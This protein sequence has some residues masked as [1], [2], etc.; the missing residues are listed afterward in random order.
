MSKPSPLADKAHTAD[1]IERSETTLLGAA[2]EHYVMAEL[3]RR[4]YIA[5]LA[6]QGVPNMDIVVTDISG[7][8]LCAIQVKARLEKGSDGGWHMRPKHEQLTEA[9]LFYCFVDFGASVEAIPR[10][11][12]MPAAK[13][14]EVIARS[15]ASWLSLPGAGG[16]VR[17]DSTVR[18]LLPNYDY[19]YRPNPNPYPSGWMNEYLGA[20]HLL[21]G[22]G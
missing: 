3:L 7:A 11:Y 14:A 5:A 6:P 12:V 10:T 13:V 18:R 21:R 15:H 2:G 17:R 4:G 22:N 1:R 20:W 16:R 8:N 9:R 19:A